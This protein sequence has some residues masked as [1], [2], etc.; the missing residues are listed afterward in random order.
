MFPTKA[1]AGWRG[2]TDAQHVQIVSEYFRRSGTFAEPIA[3]LRTP[4][5]H[6]GD[7]LYAVWADALGHG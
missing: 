4:L 2:A 5:G 3:E 6:R 7:P 1:I